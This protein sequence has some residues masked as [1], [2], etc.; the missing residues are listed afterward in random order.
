MQ[1]L[2]HFVHAYLMFVT[3][4]KFLNYKSTIKQQILFTTIYGIGAISSREIYKIFPTPFGMHTIILILLSIVLF[5]KIV[6]E[7][8]WQKSIY[9]SL[10]LVILLLI[11]DVLIF[12]PIMNIFGLSLDKA[13]SSVFLIFILLIVLTNLTLII[14]LIIGYLRN[15]KDHQINVDN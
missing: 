14:G 12:V 10:I 3:P 9:T 11:N 1:Y 15:K 7:F 2:V 4:L 6:H 8:T 5:K 13:E